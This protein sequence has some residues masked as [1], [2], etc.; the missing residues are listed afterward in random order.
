MQRH[1]VSATNRQWPAGGLLPAGQVNHLQGIIGQH[2][3]MRIFSMPNALALMRNLRR[4]LRL[5]TAATGVSIALATFAP[6]SMA[7][8]QYQVSSEWGSGFVASIRIT[9]DTNTT[10][11]NWNVNWTYNGS[12]RVSSSWNAN[13]SGSNP[14]SATGVSWNASIAPG[15]TVEFGIQGTGAAEI[16]ALTGSLC[17]PSNSSTSLSSSSSSSSAANNA[18]TILIQEN[19]TG[20]CRADGT[21]DN[22][23]SGYTGP[24]FANTPNTAGASIEWSV[25]I[26]TAGTYRLEWR[27]ANGGANARPGSILLNGN[28]VGT[29]SFDPSGGWATWT[30]AG[31]NITLTA[32]VHRIRLQATTGEGLANIDSLALTGANASAANCASVSSSSV[33]SNSSSSSS[34]TGVT[35][36]RPLSPSQ[37][38]FMV[39]IDTWNSAD[40]QKIIDLIP[41][42]IR[43]YVVMVISMSIYHEGANGNQCRWLQVENGIETARS[44]IKTAAENNIWAMVQ[45]SSGGFTHFPDYGPNADLESTIYGEL[46]RDY[47]NFLG[48]NYA[49]Q[50]WGFDED[51]SPSPQ[52]RWEHWANLLKLSNKYGG[53]LAV[54]FTGGFWG[55]SINPMAMA[56]RNSTFESALKSYSNHFI[57][58]EKFTMPYGFHDIESVSLGMYLSGFAGHY[59]IRTDR[60]GWQ[61][62]DGSDKYPVAAGSP[63]LIEHL[64]FTGQTVFDGPELI[65]LDTIRGLSNGSTS[66]GY[67]TRRWELFPQF[68]NI[69]LDIYRK[70]LDGSL[71]IL[72]RKEV[73]DRTKVVI[74]NDMNTGDDRVRYAS[75]ETLFTGLYLLDDDGT[76]LNQKSWYK[77]TGRYPAIPTVWKLNDSIANSFQVQVNRSGYNAR[78]PNITAK[79]NEFNSVFPQEY[80]GDIYAGRQENTWVTYNPYK[81]NRTASGTIPFKY[82]TCDAMSVTYSQFTTGVVKEYTN[83]LDFYLTNYDIDN[84]ALKTNVI[85]ITGASSQPT[86]TFRDRGEHQAS[87]VTSNWTNGVLTLNVNHNGPLE[88]TVNCSGS[89]SGRLTSYKTA[90]LQPPAAPPLYTGARQYE[91]EHFDFR[92]IGGQ[93]TNGINGAIRNY[94]GLGYLNFGTSASASVRDHVSVSSA[95][96][97]QLRTRYSLTGANISS[98]D[99]YVNGA[100]VATPVFTQTS[101]TSNWA[102]NQQTINLNAGSN[103]IEFRATAARS[104]II[105]FDNIVITR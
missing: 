24:G 16:P 72:D 62:V 86:F 70:I 48:I 95:G 91:A 50:F 55:A 105:Y 29:A 32:G 42:D 11:N 10:V 20:F 78:W 52:Q 92:S 81:T 38:M 54:S 80:T 59:G 26:I 88:I 12:S 76:Y 41:A 34:A 84:T 53:Y 8:C 5:A 31:A 35:M 74:V 61:N 58:Q 27:F 79:V 19:A 98:I 77:K 2:T 99:V 102:I 89:A 36:R 15:Q 21:I 90:T 25:N 22:D 3:I 28:A 37:P 67:T 1:D 65:W 47:P 13:V 96:T 63:H 9:N 75:P 104:S 17:S 6:Q 97:Y 23:H 64:T 103:T 4:N 45:P 46:F 73:I 57:I 94:Q 49:E 101:S 87:N 51:C 85:R 82:N 93:V 60:T 18:T 83:R 66:D 68:K 40:P 44:W 71:R 7:A 33:S 43:P 100:R 69:Q 39:H 14:Y 56:K 30:T